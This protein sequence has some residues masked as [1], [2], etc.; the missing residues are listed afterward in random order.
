MAYKITFEDFSPKIISNLDTRIYKALEEASGELE[1][2]VKRNTKVGRVNGGNTRGKWTHWVDPANYTAY[3]GNPLETALWLEFGTGEHAK[4]TGHKGRAGKWYI[5]IGNGRNQISQAVVDAYHMK[6]VYGKDGKKFVETT[7]IEPQRPL[8]KAYTKNK[9]K[10]S[11]HI[12]N[13]LKG[14]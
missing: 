10:I 5:L 14:L 11:N 9:K 7:G 8:H 12:Q 3:V 2:Q 13:S 4:K 6:V 1:A